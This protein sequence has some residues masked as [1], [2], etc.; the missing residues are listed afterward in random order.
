MIDTKEFRTDHSISGAD[1]EHILESIKGRKTFIDY[2]CHLGHLSFEAAIRYDVDVIAVDNFTGT[3]GDPHMRA[4]FKNYPNGFK[5]IFDDNMSKVQDRFIGRVE[6]V[7][8]EDFWSSRALELAGKVDSM[9]ID[10]SH[11]PE[12]SGE[13]EKLAN[14]LKSG[15]LMMGHDYED[16]FF[17]GV[18]KP[19][20]EL[21]KSGRFGEFAVKGTVFSMVVQ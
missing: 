10:S 21:R 13:Y 1:V 9:F 15:G 16:G 17:L 5:E 20:T 4:T 14:L 8:S 6:A 3:V 2:G 12:E 7:T 11:R 19:V 18:I